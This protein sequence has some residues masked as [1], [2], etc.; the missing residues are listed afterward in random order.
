MCQFPNRISDHE[1]KILKKENAE[2]VKQH[3]AN[4]ASESANLDSDS[5]KDVPQARGR[6]NATDIIANTKPMER[7]KCN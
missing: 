7:E 4:T 6:C 1:D 2:L 5:D 3:V